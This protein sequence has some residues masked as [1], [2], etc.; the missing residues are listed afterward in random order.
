[1]VATTDS[2]VY[3]GAFGARL[4]D[5]F[6][7]ASMVKPI[8]SVAAMQLVDQG[9]IKLEE[10][11]AEYLPEL[12]ELQVLEGFDPHT[13]QPIFRPAR[14]PVTLKHLLTHTSGF[15]YD[16]WYEDMFR[17][18]TQTGTLGA[19]MVPA[20]TPLL[21]EPGTSWLYGYSLEWVGRLVERIGGLTLEEYFQRNILRPL[22]MTDTSYILP[23]KKFPRLA[24]R[25]RRELDGTFTEEPRTLPSPPKAFNGGGALY[26]TASDYVKF[27][28]M[29]LR[30]GSPVLTAELV[31]QMT[32]NQIGALTVSKL[33][34]FQPERSSDFELYPSV[35]GKDSPS[36]FGFGFLISE[37]RLAWAGVINT[38]FWIDPVRELCAVVMMQFTPFADAAA[39]GVL[40]DFER[41][42]YAV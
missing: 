11:V 27:M 4:E 30:Q 37:G 19:R 13:A 14:T 24:R 2:V 6:Y 15:A 34:S 42:V 7:V 17:Y 20:P 39:M 12:A 36:K 26:S 10:P 28:Q 5:I 8:T 31:R 33:I 21:C 1:M 23:V 18:A 22:G 38:F 32:R 29:I 25:Y 41:A 16:T 40:H 9:S 35:P 3:E